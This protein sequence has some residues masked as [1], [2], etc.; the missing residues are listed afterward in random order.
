MYPMGWECPKCGKVYA[1][2][3][4][5][6]GTCGKNVVT[7]TWSPPRCTCGQSTGTGI[8]PIHG[9]TYCL[10]DAGDPGENLNFP[11]QGCGE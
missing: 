9:G 4:T 10:I 6:C 8:C 2:F 3:V 7:I 5:E 11:Y 1:P